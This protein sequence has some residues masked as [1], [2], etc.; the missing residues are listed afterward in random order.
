MLYFHVSLFLVNAGMNT[1][2][3]RS[4]E[5]SV[6]I[7]FERTFRNLDINRP[8]ANSPDELE[9]NFCGCGW[10]QHMLIP[11]GK[12]EGFPCQLFA[13]VSDYQKDY[14]NVFNLLINGYRFFFNISLCFRWI[15]I[16][17]AVAVTLLP[18]VECVIVCIPIVVR[19]A[20]PS[21]VCP[22]KV[23]RIWAIS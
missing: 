22:V 10:P 20:T 18:I 2:R 6:T 5:S 15:K 21:I 1:I 17:W 7:P 16:L 9:F 11:K 12:P 23:S 19:W 4:D 14:V 13:M 3:R 8:V